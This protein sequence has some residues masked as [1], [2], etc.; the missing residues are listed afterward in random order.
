MCFPRGFDWSLIDLIPLYC[1]FSRAGQDSLELNNILTRLPK[2][3]VNVTEGNLKW[4]TNLYYGA[5]TTWENK[6]VVEYRYVSV[7]NKLSRP[8]TTLHVAA[9]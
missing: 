5:Q 9:K 2:H 1:I 4:S 3:D 7:K 6:T 8:I